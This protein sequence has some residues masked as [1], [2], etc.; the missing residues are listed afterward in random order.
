MG[1]EKRSE[2]NVPFPK[3]SGICIILLSYFFEVTFSGET[4]NRSNASGSA[5]RDIFLFA[6]SLG[7]YFCYYLMSPSEQGS[8]VFEGVGTF[9][10]KIG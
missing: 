2:Q 10:Y 6:S 5:L 1:G 4:N 3:E 7:K 9:R 8:C